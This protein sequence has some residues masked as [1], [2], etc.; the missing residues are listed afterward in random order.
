[1]TMLLTEGYNKLFAN[2]KFLRFIFCISNSYFFECWLIIIMRRRMRG[3]R[4]RRRRRRTS[5]LYRQWKGISRCLPMIEGPLF[6]KSYF[7]APP[8]TL[9]YEKHFFNLSKSQVIN[10]EISSCWELSINSH[11][12]LHTTFRSLKLDKW[13]RR[14]EGSRKKNTVLT[15]YRVIA[16]ES[17]FKYY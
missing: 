12:W 14:G 2:W 6:A 17:S 3:W 1:M 5:T 11:I 15:D 16:S 7:G 9:R 8:Y 10:K 13:L 4:T